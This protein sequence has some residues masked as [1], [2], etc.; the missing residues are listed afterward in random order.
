V[1]TSPIP[2]KAL[3]LNAEP[4]AV[5]SHAVTLT[6]VA[7]EYATG[8]RVLLAATAV[9]AAADRD[10]AALDATARAELARMGGLSAEAVGFERVALWRVPYAQF[11]Q[12]PGWREQRPSIACGIPGLWRAS[13]VLHSSSLEGAARGGAQAAQALLH[14]T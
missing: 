8:G 9:G 7:P 12:P 1:R 6:D 14:A 11:A 13:E 2:G 4:N 5:I 3:W 10:D